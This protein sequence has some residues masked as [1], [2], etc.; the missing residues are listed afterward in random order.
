MIELKD[1]SVVYQSD[2]AQCTALKDIS[3]TIPLGS[4]C[5]IIGPSGSGKSTVLKVIAGIIKD[6]SGEVLIGGEKASAK[7]QCIGFMPQNYGLLPWK[8]V[9]ENIFLGAKIKRR[10]TKI[11]KSKL[12]SIMHQLGIDGLEK[13]YPKELS[14][15][16]Q[17]RVSLARIF[18]LKPDVL[19]M[20]EPFS[21]LDAITREEIQD[22]F[23]KIRQK[24]NM[25][26][27]LVTHYVEEAVYLGEKIV[28]MAANAGKI[29]CVIDNP[30]FGREG[31]R[32]TAEFYQLSDTLR[33]RIKETWENLA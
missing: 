32:S 1:V 28:I 33:C 30:L 2:D 22:I 3:L 5:A 18:L 21:A 26:T 9:E 8:T 4:T 11:D 31:V 13:R 6:F 27:V 17:Q 14:G 19:L 15:G 7:T 25:T 29:N 24:H 20:D 23:L 12:R 16:Q 10:Q